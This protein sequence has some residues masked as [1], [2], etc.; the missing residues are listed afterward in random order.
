MTTKER[1]ELPRKMFPKGS[2]LALQRRTLTTVR[3][4]W[5]STAISDSIREDSDAK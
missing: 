5:E 2:F 1:G 3:F 4:T